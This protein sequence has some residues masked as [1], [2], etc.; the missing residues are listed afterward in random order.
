MPLYSY[1]SD[2]ADTVITSFP[3]K[4]KS[5]LN[6]PDE[7]ESHD[8]TDGDYLYD[9]TDIWRA[10]FREL[11]N[12]TSYGFRAANSAHTLAWAIADQA[13]TVFHKR[14]LHPHL[15][16]MEIFEMEINEIVSHRVLNP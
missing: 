16:F 10:V 7:A 1:S 4:R 13:L 9:S 12:Q 6:Q 2:L 5:D 3:F 8:P 11:R 14:T 15:Q